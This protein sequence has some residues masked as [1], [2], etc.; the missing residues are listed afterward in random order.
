MSIQ[1]KSKD[2]YSEFNQKSDRSDI[3]PTYPI[4]NYKLDDY[5]V[6]VTGLSSLESN[7]SIKNECKNSLDANDN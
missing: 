1:N 4:N 7:R 6:N 5:M 3:Y 2:Y